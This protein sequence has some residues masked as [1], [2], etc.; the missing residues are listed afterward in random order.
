MRV[1]NDFTLYKRTLASGMVVVYYH[2]YDRSGKRLPGRS[3]GQSSLTAARVECNR[4]MREGLLIPDTAVSPTF[5]EFASLWWDWDTCDY[6][7]NQS[8]RKD[9]TQT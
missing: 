8:S 6:L 9:L 1:H 3:T 4:L 2:A 7:K 5:A